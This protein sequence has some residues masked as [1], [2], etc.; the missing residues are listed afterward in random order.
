MT[1][2]SIENLDVRYGQFKAVRSV[3]LQVGAGEVV[4][5][6]GAN[7]AGK[8]T[9][10]RTLAGAIRPAG[11]RILF[12]DKDVT[13]MSAHERVKS[14]MVLVPEGRRLFAR[15]TVEENLQLGGLVKRGGDWTVDRIFSIF[16][17]L[18]KRRHA[19]TGTLSGGEQQ[20]T[21]IGRALMTNP[22][23]IFF[24]EIS[25]G[26]SPLVVDQ[27]YASLVELLKSGVTVV[28]VEQDLKRAMAV[29]G[30]AIC[31]LE[32]QVVLDRPMAQTTRDEITEAYFGLKRGQNLEGA[33]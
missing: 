7:G 18:V 10:M 17:N 15:M 19:K 3:S 32:G 2:L 13:A 14:G 22:D 16:P 1:L 4:A 5:M 21:A 8:T 33:H 9:L 24:D 11:G 6:I 26:L 12:K 29:A 31:M 27:V 20:A 25:L 30:R 23:V 28:L